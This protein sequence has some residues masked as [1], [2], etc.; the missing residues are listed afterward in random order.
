[1]RNI[2][3]G[4]TRRR[5]DEIKYWRES[6]DAT[7]LSPV[8][9]H[10]AEEPILVDE[11]ATHVMPRQE[12]PQPFNFGPLGALTGMKITEV[13][14][15]ETRVQ[16]LED[17]MM[18]IERENSRSVP[19]N[20]AQ[21]TPIRNG[22][23]SSI[24]RPKTKDSD[25]SAAIN[26]RFR[27]QQEQMY[28]QE[29]VPHIYSR[30][31]ST[32]NSQNNAYYPYD[33]SEN[34]HTEPTN[35]RPLSTSTTIRG[36]PSTPSRS[37]DGPLTAEHFTTLQNLIAT[38]QSARQ[39]LEALVISLQEQIRGLQS[40]HISALN[41]NL[42]PNS[43]FSTFERHESND[44]FRRDGYGEEFEPDE[45][46]ETPMEM[47]GRRFGDEC[48]GVAEEHGNGNGTPRT[49]SLSQITMNKA[50]QYV[51]VNF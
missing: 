10:K 14:S 19:P 51:G 43:A 20:S 29:P 25:N 40:P 13:A 22:R 16:R 4:V 28:L 49:L 7:L 32:V 50:S 37:R 21:N 47:S 36:Q 30:R 45:V 11:N 18:N 33:A 12:Q 17:R 2:V 1:M 8:S 23:K 34:Q 26:S 39:N 5:S 6:Y 15:L 27:E 35:P 3:G 46:F 9:S 42:D 31:R 48:F 41:E 24:P 44:D 38:E